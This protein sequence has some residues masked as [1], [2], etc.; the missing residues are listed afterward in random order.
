MRVQFPSRH[1]TLPIDRNPNR[2]AEYY[3]N[4]GV[5][6]HTI[7]AWVDYVVPTGRMFELS[8]MYL[9]IKRATYSTDARPFT[10]NILFKPS[11]MSSTYLRQEVGV[12]N[13]YG[14][15]LEIY[16]PGP[17]YLQAGDELILQTADLSVDGTTVVIAT[18]IGLLFDAV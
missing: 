12:F 18:V 14:L 5:S 1:S 9:A 13:D 2:V 3:Y 8:Y 10:A 7:T 4:S 16:I 6:P 17:I 11:G 15:G